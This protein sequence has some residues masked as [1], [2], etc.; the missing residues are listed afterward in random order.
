MHLYVILAVY[1]FLSLVFALL[2]IRHGEIPRIALW[3]G[4]ILVIAARFTL[5]DINQGL[6][7]L[8][9]CALGFSVYFPVYLFARGKLGLADVWYAAF[10][11]CVFGPAW[12]YAVSIAGCILALVYMGVYRPRSI[13]FIPF[14]AAGG[15]AALPFF[16]NAVPR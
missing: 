15:L 6:A 12:W 10:T 8:A 13:A 11:G 3:C 14:M 7:G 5:P 4:I 1:G 9:G 16:I 2:D